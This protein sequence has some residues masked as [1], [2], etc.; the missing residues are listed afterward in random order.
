MWLSN[1]RNKGDV[2]NLIPLEH[3]PMLN[4]QC[5]NGFDYFNKSCTKSCKCGYQTSNLKMLPQRRL[6]WKEYIF[7][8]TRVKETQ[9][10]NLVSRCKLLH[11]KERFYIVIAVINYFKCWSRVEFIEVG[12]K[13]LFCFC[14]Y[15]WA[16]GL[17]KE[18]IYKLKE[19]GDSSVINQNNSAALTRTHSFFTVI[20]VKSL[21][22][23]N[24]PMAIV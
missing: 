5:L 8:K 14:P 13:F 9:Y 11:P 6:V 4:N 22:C 21:V 23:S 7:E 10:L 3:F 20:S 15:S 17:C 16:W 18:L 12:G 1:F 19:W 24:H 2:S